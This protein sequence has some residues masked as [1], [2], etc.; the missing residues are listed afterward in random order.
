M[1]AFILVGGVG[2]RLRP[3]TCT[4]AKPNIPVANKPLIE[5]LIIQL[6]SIG[7]TDI[8]L[9]VHYKSHQFTETLGDGKT[10]GVDIIYSEEEDALGTAGAIKLAEPLLRDAP[11]FVL[12]SDIV[13][14]INFS[15]M[16]VYYYLLQL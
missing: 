3:L 5:Y 9:G 6:E 14:S 1:K 11:F 8:V 13:S 10:L 4:R 2:T 16:L 12:N 7:I 15:K